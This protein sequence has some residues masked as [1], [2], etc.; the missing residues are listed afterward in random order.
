[1]AGNNKIFSFQLWNGPAAKTVQ[2]NDGWIG[3]IKIEL[4]S[5]VKTWLQVTM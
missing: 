5:V 2:M 1:M 3:K 4:S